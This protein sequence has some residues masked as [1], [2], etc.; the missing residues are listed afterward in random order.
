[1]RRDSRQKGMGSPLENFYKF[2][3]GCLETISRDLEKVLV[4]ATESEQ[5]VNLGH[6][7]VARLDSLSG[8]LQH[9]RTPSWSNIVAER[10]ILSRSLFPLLVV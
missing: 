9:Q 6:Y 3:S 8:F 5:N 1:M 7:C 10:P 2:V 4:A